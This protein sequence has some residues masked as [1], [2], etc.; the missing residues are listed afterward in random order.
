MLISST[1]LWICMV[2]AVGIEPT[3]ESTF[4]RAS[5]S[6]ADGLIFASC[7]VHQQTVHLASSLVPLMPEQTLK[8]FLYGRPLSFSLQVS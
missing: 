3:S 4:T 8:V 6:A 1:L 2:E 7:T 5:P